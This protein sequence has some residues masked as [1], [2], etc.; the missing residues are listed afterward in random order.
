[1]AHFVV[2]FLVLDGLLLVFLLTL[3]EQANEAAHF[4]AL[5]LLQLPMQCP[6]MECGIGRDGLKLLLFD[7]RMM[8]MGDER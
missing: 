4:K 6:H 2:F 3:F 8:T 7:H 1:M 5:A